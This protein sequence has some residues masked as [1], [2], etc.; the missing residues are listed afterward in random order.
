MYFEPLFLVHKEVKCQNTERLGKYN[1]NS[2]NFSY[3]LLC[4]FLFRCGYK[5]IIT[6]LKQ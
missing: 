4:I 6:I 1:Y 3:F 5:I 2:S